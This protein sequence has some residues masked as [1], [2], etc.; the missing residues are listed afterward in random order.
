M[1]MTIKKEKPQFNLDHL[2]IDQGG[3]DAGPTQALSHLSHG[4]RLPKLGK[5]QNLKNPYYISLLL[6][7][8]SIK[9]FFSAH[10]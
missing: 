2:R 1:T 10:Q 3:F 9:K 5:P 8:T 7:N 6:I 4:L